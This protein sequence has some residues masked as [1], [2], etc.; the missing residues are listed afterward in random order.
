MQQSMRFILLA[1]YVLVSFYTSPA[2]N[3][4]FGLGS[5][6]TF[7]NLA[8]NAASFSN[9]D[10]WYIGLPL[11]HSVYIGGNSTLSLRQML[12]QGNDGRFYLDFNKM[13]TDSPSLNELR[14]SPSLQL[15]TVGIRIGNGF[16]SLGLALRNQVQLGY[17]PNLLNFLANGNGNTDSPIM[18]NQESLTAQHYLDASIGYARYL[19]DGIKVGGR[20]HILRSIGTLSL[21]RWYI[22]IQTDEQSFP[23]YA[24]NTSAEVSVAAT[25]A[26]AILLDSNDMRSVSP[27]GYGT[28]IAFDLGANYRIN[29]RWAFLLSAHNLGNFLFVSA[30]DA[31]RIYTAGT[32]QITFE[33]FSLEPG[34]DKAATLDDQVNDLRQQLQEAFPIAVQPSKVQINLLGPAITIGATADWTPYLRTAFFLQAISDHIGLRQHLNTSLF[35]HPNRTIEL[36]GGISW[37]N[38][39][40]LSIGA[41]MV[42][43][44]GPIRWHILSEN[45]LLAINP[46]TA[47]SGGIRI[48]ISIAVNQKNGR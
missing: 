43:Q 17:S 25:G 24:L 44:V 6:L 15:A 30:A 19:G 13:A 5:R 37:G 41:G 46:V 40:K 35:W 4:A 39:S 31:K 47:R 27:L 11:L 14:L 42:L 12:T 28:G 3:P 9:N 26:Y 7:L 10:K 34:N 18:L 29:P 2:Q 45:I 20:L 22:R 38:R 16:W 32:G 23:T 48:G 33:G 21:D 8:Y 36:I 1:Y